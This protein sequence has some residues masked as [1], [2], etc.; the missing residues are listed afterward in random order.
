MGLKIRKDGAWVNVSSKTNGSITA[1]ASGA[2]SAGDPVVLN[3][4]GTV[5]KVADSG[6]GTN[7][8]TTNFLGFSEASYANNDTAAINIFSSI[9]K[10]QSGLL[11]IGKKYYVQDD[12]TL[13]TT[14]GDIWVE[15]GTALSSTTILVSG[16][17][18]LK[19]GGTTRPFNTLGWKIPLVG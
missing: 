10:N 13:S 11:Q 6:S 16:G 5:S 9:D 12:G 15:A 14:P 7:L 8:T 3:S 18:A 17:A 2:L 1:T 4:N 19:L